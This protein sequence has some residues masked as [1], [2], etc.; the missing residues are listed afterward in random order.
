MAKAGGEIGGCAAMNAIPLSLRLFLSFLA[1]ALLP[2]AGAAWL[3]LAS[4]ER[5]MTETVLRNIDSIADKKADQIDIFIGERL[6]NVQAYSRAPL[7]SEALAKFSQAFRTGGLL[8]TAAPDRR[9]RP[10]LTA[11]ATSA[12]ESVYYYDLLL[13]DREGNVVFSLARE[14]DLGT[15][16]NSGPYRD[17]GLGQAYRQAMLSLHSDLSPF[18]RYAPSNYRCAAFLA[19]P[20]MQADKT[21]G[22][23]VLQLNLDALTQV[24]ADR[25]GLGVSGETVLAQRMGADI[26]YTAPLKHIAHAEFNHVL[27]FER[28]DLPMRKALSGEHGHGLV[29]DYAGGLVTAA[30][31]Y[32]PALRWGMAVKIDAAE[33]LAPAYQARR[34]AVLALMAFLALSAWMAVAFSRSL[35]RPLRGL[36]RAAE[37][38]T[39][40][41]WRA[42]APAE[43]GKELILLAGAFNAMAEKTAEAHANLEAK[44]RARTVELAKVSALQSAILDNAAVSIITT[45]PQGIITSFNRAA[46]YMLGYS[47]EEMIGKRSPSVFHLPSQIA[48]RARLLTQELG[49]AIEP[50]FE[51]FAAKSRRNLPNALEWTYISKN[52]CQFPVLLSVTALRDDLGDIA[53]FLGIATDISEHKRLEDALKRSDQRFRTLFD[54]SP[55]PV[56][57]I[58]S[59]HFVDCNRAAVEFLGYPSKES[60]LNTHPAQ[61]SPSH[62]PDGEDSFS[63]AERMMALTL[64]NGM[65]RFEWVH[66]RADGSLFTAEVT[67]SAIEIQGCPLIYCN[68][69]DISERKAAEQAQSLLREGLEAKYAVAKVLQKND[70]ALQARLDEALAIVFTMSGLEI[71]Q[72]GGIFLLPPGADAL[73]LC[74]TRGAFSQAFLRDEQS[75]PLGRCL[76]GRAAQSG[77]IL[78]SDHCFEDHRHENRWPDMVAHGHYI[79]P[80]LAGVELQGVLFLY[81]HPYPNRDSVRIDALRQ[82]GDLFGLAI[83]NDRAQ[84]QMLEAKEHAESANRAKSDFLANMSHE[85][86]TPMNAV[87]GLSQLLLD[88][89]LNPKQRDYLGK[90]QNS[91]RALLSII[92]DIL[93]YSKIEAGRIDIERV[94]FSL[95]EV[96]D[97]VGNL[98]SV[99]AEEKGLELL[100]E[101]ASGTP[102]LLQGDP[103]RLSQILNNLVGNAVKFT[104]QGSV[105]VKVEAQP[106]ADES[107]LLGVQVRDTGVGI[108]PE[109]QSQLFQAFSQADA[110]TTRKYG[111]TGLGLAIS[112]RL[113]ELMGGEIGVDSVLGQ[114]SVFYFTARVWPAPQRRA[115]D[116]SQLR[117]MKALL[118]D[119]QEASRQVLAG[120]LEAWGFKTAQASDAAAGLRHIQAAA[121]AGAPFELLLIDWKMPGMDGVEMAREV[122][123]QAALNGTARLPIVIMV[124]AFGRS[125]VLES[126][127]PA[128]L[129]AVLEK[130]VMPSSLFDA[131]IS[132]QGQAVA[133][134]EKTPQSK[135]RDLSA[136]TRAIQGARVLLAE[137]NPTNQLVAK[138]LLLKMGLLV[139]TAQDGRE[140][141]E[142]AGRQHYDAVLMDLQMPVMDG[143]AAARAIRKLD[144]C[145]TLPI[146]AMTAA[147]MMKDQRETEAAG[148]NHHV[149][150]PIEPEK[151]ADALLQWIPPGPRSA[152]A[153]PALPPDMAPFAL[154]GLDLAQA[155]GRVGHSWASL[156]RVL[157]GF[158]Q[159]FQNAEA[160]LADC[161]ETGQYPEMARL[162]H[163]LK[164]LAPAIGAE[165]L[166]Q[167]A[168]R[169]E[170]E[171]LQGQSASWPELKDS[172][173]AALTAI[174]KLE[175]LDL[176]AASASAAIA[177]L[178]WETLLPQMQV[179][180]AMLAKR[181]SQARQQ[182]KALQARLQGS[183]LA[184]PFKAI[185][186]AVNRLQFQEAL[187]YLRRLIAEQGHR[188]Q[189]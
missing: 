114:G 34:L 132:I 177:E 134:E 179:L 187:A 73:S 46:E 87:I 92:N 50:G 149:S 185:E 144:S 99:G 28:A 152:L 20:V 27:P 59:N 41:D 142:K 97:T 159:D 183:P 126:A 1:V 123:R 55:D 17:S 125:H 58:E 25:T 113:A 86:R 48:E 77:E 71:E 31:R 118:V 69:R 94:D 79:V 40:G 178:E 56:W 148:M 161:L 100:F 62:Q 120:M 156:R 105:W 21:I 124:T 145:K 138:E 47:A 3:A 29:Q 4:F 63:K 146:I 57:I 52:G 104:Q 133:A 9:Y 173:A 54:S 131:I 11:L 95:E 127:L 26:L 143:F 167:A 106:Q 184:T 172:L 44:V 147:A 49:V 141:V 70:Q 154:P 24:A 171:F 151:L 165:A 35:A 186:I 180:E 169:C 157:L 116:P 153:S 76:C 174:A 83:A 67:L 107:L 110:S 74:M 176:G 81:T 89:D 32:L 130:P 189:D 175:P 119:D 170:A 117:G 85:I 16:L 19:A 14:P 96:L 150:K 109:R 122:E 155:V 7:V 23:I 38:I 129:D 91:S 37:L 72:K 66:A 84:A 88:T 135:P 82:L 90:I 98:F 78:V 43:G 45:T 162:A 136:Y 61:L 128:H 164:G 111:G 160:T 68:W 51:V 5:T 2:L 64:Q 137:D 36:A 182:V 112:K 158:Y 42:R 39:A 13:I 168:L 8:G 65:H 10:A 15:N 6:T 121:Q 188:R 101:I 103:L 22:A 53:G 139:E 181:Q 80:L 140:A 30:W 115:R 12:Q 93:D 163:T 108:A 102:A 75:V 166:H 60:L 33:A 18:S